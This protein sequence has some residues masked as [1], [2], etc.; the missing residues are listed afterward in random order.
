MKVRFEEL[1]V[2]Q[3]RAA[4]ASWQANRLAAPQLF[5]DEIASVVARI[6]ADDFVVGALYPSRSVPGV[7][8]ILCP[9]TRYHVYYVIDEEL[10]AAVIL[11]VWGGM[12]RRG[13]S[14]RRT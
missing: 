9:R 13:P 7:R 6:R 14:L 8:R 1:A 5:A 10:N 11:A 2:A 12:R 3:V 4:H